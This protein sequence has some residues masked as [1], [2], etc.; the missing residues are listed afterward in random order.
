VASVP[1]VSANGTSYWG[2]FGVANGYELPTDQKLP[3]NAQGNTTYGDTLPGW[4][5]PTGWG[6]IIVSSFAADLITLEQ[7]PTQLMTVNSAG[8]AYDAGAW[9][10]MQLNQS[11][12]IHVNASSALGLTGVHVNAVFHGLDGVNSSVPAI[13]LTQALT[14]SPGYDFT[15]DTGAAPF[16]QPGFVIFTVGNNTDD[17]IGFAYDWISYP[18]ATGNLTVT[19]TAPSS[20]SILSGVPEFNPWPFGYN[21]PTIV[22]PDCCTTQNFFT[23]HVTYDGAP[24]YNAFV[25]AQV[26]SLSVLAWQ[27]SRIQQ[28]TQSQGNPHEMSPTILS[29]AYT[30]MEGDAVVYT[31]NL[32]APSLYYVNATW[33]GATGGTVYN[34]TPGLNIKTTDAYGGEYSQFSTVEYV[35]KQLRQPT[36]TQNENLWAPNYNNQSS[37]YNLLYTW[38]G[39]ILPLSANDYAGVAQSGV[40]LWLANVDFGGTNKFY[41]YEPNFGLDGVTNVSGT[42]NYTDPSGNTS[43]FIPDNQTANNFF[44]YPNGQT[45][46]FAFIAAS[47]PGQYNRTFSYTEP[48]VPTNPNNPKETIT[49]QYNDSLQRNYT[50]VPILVGEN[51]VNVTTQT[52]AGVARSF[53]GSGSNISVKVNVLLPDNDPFLEGIGTDWLPGLEHVVSVS[54][55]VDG[56]Y[57]GDLSPGPASQWQNF[58]VNGNL[59]GSYSN[60]THDLKI[61]AVDSLGHIFTRDDTFV[62]GAINITNLGL[63]NT[64]TVLPYI[65]NWTYVIPAG[66][67]NNHTFSQSLDIRYV[68][69]GCG[70]TTV[71]PT[72]VNYTIKIK[73]GV[74]SYSQSLNTTLLNLQGFYSGAN[75]LP[76]GQYQIIIWLNANH[77]GSIAS[78]VDTQLV[79]DDVQGEI[80]GPGAGALVPLGNVTI[81]YAY[82]GQYIENATLYVYPNGTTT[83]PVFRA[84]AFVPGLSGL[85][86]GA[87]TWTAVTPGT[88]EVILAL[89]TPY[90]GQNVSEQITVTEVSST[91]FLN[92]THSSGILGGL[93]AAAAGTLMAIIAAI[94]GLMVGLFLAPALRGGPARPTTAAGGRA[95]PPAWQEDAKGPTGVTCAICHEQFETPFAMH[96]HQKIAHGIEE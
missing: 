82:S 31:W 49:C 93:S 67:M 95:A 83:N 69:N 37:Y 80:N 44:E 25:T 58:T 89:G 59:T 78:Q 15:L 72:V 35:L 40:K 45:A 47:D 29:G 79:F 20:S 4:D 30:N 88:Y 57:A 22:N 76:P 19:V 17:S 2:N 8:S 39:E 52:A 85:R 21:A 90:G 43:I 13:T 74:T 53:F 34:I 18:S 12:S 3:Y 9:D 41:N 92:Q 5:F 75:E 7:M 70:G 61:V 50:G 91:A 14:P 84:G 23:V 33:G 26:P 11:Y 36:T 48:C 38:Q 65:L 63:Q 27:G 56:V 54:A 62:V 94:V 96:Q 68:A 51:P 16:N 6:S 64:Y 10:W 73:D 66:E 86:G 1:G 60:G 24:V 32:V 46:G 55:Y 71:C 87:S 81:S 28:S 77:S 42:S